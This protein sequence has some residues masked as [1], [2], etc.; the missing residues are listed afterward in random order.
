MRPD[1]SP[2]SWFAA[3][4]DRTPERIALTYAGV[5]RTYAQMLDRVV[6]LAGVLSAAGARSG[7]RVG[8]LGSNHPLGYE[9]LLACSTT[10]AIFVPINIRLA[11]PEIDYIVGDAG[12]RALL[13]GPGFAEL[14]GRLHLEGIDH[15]FTAE[16]VDVAHVDVER[17]I[18][19]SAGL[20][21]VV[22]H[23]HDDDDVAVLIYTS[24]TTGSPKGAMLT[25][26]NL[27]WNNVNAMHALDVLENEIALVMAPIF[28]IA[29]INGLTLRTWQKGGE[30]VLL[31]RFDPGE[32][33]RQVEQRRVTTLFGVPTMLKAVAEHDAFEAADL[34]SI[35]VL[36]SSSAPVPMDLL[37]IYEA[38][39]LAVHQG[40]GLTEAAPVATMLGTEWATTKIGS[41]GIAPLFCD[42]RIAPPVGSASPQSSSEDV[43][44]ETRRQGE[45]LVRG[46][47]VM[48][49]YWN[50]PSATAETIDAEGWLHTGDVGYQD[51]DGFLY[52]IDRI[53]DLII[54][55]GENIYPAEVENVLQEHP[56]VGEVAVIGEADDHWGEHVVAVVVPREGVEALSL[57]EVRDFAS[58]KL[59]RYKLPQRLVTVSALPYN[60][61]GKVLRRELR[62]RLCTPG[63]AR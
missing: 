16:S 27:W 17:A 50:D 6:R 44:S 57:D 60:G 51:E 10:G 61:A 8:Y 25:N 12:L 15:L 30:V 54:S 58:K 24:G 35:R 39:G 28:H 62:T 56:K 13:V 31:E 14:S 38:R 55:G 5:S 26:G 63:V 36:L 1:V 43:S 23:H 3:R 42:V 20:A 11:P 19:S 34:S 59:A 47:N 52:V 22:R 37:K 33:I 46:P 45:I 18:G 4:A 53:R 32:V 7:E 29:G 21:D 9:L 40:Y 2:G 48:K 41:A 49:G